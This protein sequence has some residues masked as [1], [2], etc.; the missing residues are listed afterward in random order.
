[1]KMLERGV[2]RGA[3]LVAP[4][5]MSN[6]YAPWPEQVVTFFGH[7][8]QLPFGRPASMR[9]FHYRYGF[10][11]KL[12]VGTPERERAE[13]LLGFESLRA[14]TDMLWH[15]IGFVLSGGKRSAGLINASKITQPVKVIGGDHD[16]A[17]PARVHRRIA[18]RLSA[19]YHLYQGRAHW[20]I[21]EPGW[22]QVAEEAVEWV[23]TTL[24]EDA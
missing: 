21:S 6:L 16:R 10:F 7:V 22:K 23:R 17:V 2:G 4:A 11:N 5:G 3:L 19:Q 15:P 1:M 20:I 14:T 8:L 9:P 18:K 12:A 13:E 24:A